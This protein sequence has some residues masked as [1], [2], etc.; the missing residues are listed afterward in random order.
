MGFWWLAF[1]TILFA[2][3]G[4]KLGG[5]ID[6]SIIFSAAIFTILMGFGWVLRVNR[7][8]FKLLL[9]MMLTSIYIIAVLLSSRTPDLQIFLR[10]MR[11][12]LSSLLLGTIFYT[13]TSVGLVKVEGLL[14]AIIFSL[15]ILAVVMLAQIIFP[16]V[17]PSFAG[18]YGFNKAL[19]E[20][21]AFGLTAGYD[22]AGYLVAFCSILAL[23]LY[24]VTKK[25]SYFTLSLVS[26]A[27]VMFSSRSA[28]AL[29]AGLF[30]MMVFLISKKN[31]RRFFRSIPMSGVILLA[32]ILYV[33]PLFLSTFEWFSDYGMPV[34]GIEYEFTTQFA[35]TSLMGGYADMWFLPQGI[36]EAVFGTARNIDSSDIGYIQIIFMGGFVLLAFILSFYIYSSFILLRALRDSFSLQTIAERAHL[37]AL[38]FSIIMI[39]AIMVVGNLKNL[40]FLTRGYHELFIILCFS[41]LGFCQYYKRRRRQIH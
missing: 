5:I 12:L 11:A 1:I 36:W 24:V 10:T 28:M 38:Q 7:S 25:K 3:F 32:V 6:L 34:S 23:A 27:A 18:I 40:Y 19:R 9:I 33:T 16:S 26:G 31:L 20:Y 37:E 30:M 17:Q 2:L 14:K 13:F 15:T 21:R 35:K 29:F 4:P 41:G 22:S 39:A 8:A